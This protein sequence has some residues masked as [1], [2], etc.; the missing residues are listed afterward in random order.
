MHKQLFLLFICLLSSVKGIDS[1]SQVFYIGISSGIGGTKY[2]NSR[3]IFIGQPFNENWDKFST[4]GAEIVYVPSK[5][6]YSLYSGLNY[7][8]RHGNSSNLS[9]GD[10]KFNYLKLPLG[11]NFLV[12]E[13]LGFS[14]NLGLYGSYLLSY[15]LD[16]QPEDFTNTLRRWQS[17]FDIGI[18]IVTKI[19]PNVLITLK[20]ENSMDLSHVFIND[21]LT[22]WGKSGTEKIFGS[23]TYI[24]LK[25]Y[26]NLKN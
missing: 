23:D 12:G 14:F 6:P 24:S 16:Y 25:C 1:Y 7:F 21:I 8:R 2:Y 9:F 4:I 3:Y 5:E 17:G 15:S 18:G 11:F 22:K 20:L 19:I 13:K 26:Y 10:S